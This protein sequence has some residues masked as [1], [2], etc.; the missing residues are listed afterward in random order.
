MS[1]NDNHAEGLEKAGILSDALPYM[2]EFAGETVV[3]KY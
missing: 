3:V 2:R 1:K